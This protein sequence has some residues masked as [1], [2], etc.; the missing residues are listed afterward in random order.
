MWLAVLDMLFEL[1]WANW[2]KY[3]LKYSDAAFMSDQIFCKHNLQDWEKKEK[4]TSTS[5]S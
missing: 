1:V 2:H 4:K 3:W 5:T